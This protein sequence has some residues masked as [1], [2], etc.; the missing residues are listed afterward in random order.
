MSKGKCSS[1]SYQ[2]SHTKK[3]LL[4]SFFI[5]ISGNDKE[6]KHLFLKAH[7]LFS[8]HSHVCCL[9]QGRLCDIVAQVSTK[10]QCQLRTSITYKSPVPISDFSFSDYLLCFLKAIPQQ[11]HIEESFM[12]VLHSPGCDSSWPRN[13]EHV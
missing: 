13:L 3:Y 12:Y 2:C 5:I 11:S 8:W 6:R 1:V 7:Q 9:S 10:S 4:L